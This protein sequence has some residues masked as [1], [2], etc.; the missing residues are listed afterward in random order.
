MIEFFAAIAV[1][2][3][4][5][6]VPAATGLRAWLIGRLGRRAYVAGYSL[7]SLA[8]IAWV[9]AAAL[10]AP[11]IALWE[12]SRATALVPLIAMLP[13]SVL[14]AGAAFEPNPL[15]VTFRS[16]LPD[17]R[18][19]G[20]ATL[21]R[22]PLLWAF[23]LWSASHLIANGD[24][25]GFILFGSLAVFSL[26]GMKRLERRARQR[27]SAADYAAA[28]ALTSGGLGE[29][30]RRV[31]SLQSLVDVF[32]GLV[33]YAALLYLHGPVIGVEPLAWFA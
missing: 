24:L 10:G 7:V 21:L 14:V 22:H 31:A 1:F 32:V 18:K 25:V 3:A 15:S 23:F 11:Y 26:A 29:R 27:L 28:L 33:L 8:A 19:S 4:A 20:L 16:G 17:P 30:L 6:V 5:H 13:A 12:A 9:I 2:L